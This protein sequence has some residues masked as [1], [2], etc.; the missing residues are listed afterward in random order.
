MKKQD[1][2]ILDIIKKSFNFN[3][4]SYNFEYN[5]IKLAKYIKKVSHIILQIYKKNQN[6]ILIGTNEF[7]SDLLPYYSDKIY[8]GYIDKR[9]IGG[10]ITNW[11]VIKYTIQFYREQLKKIY[12]NKY[13]NINDKEFLKLFRFIDSLKYLQGFPSIIIFLN[14]DKERSAL[15]ECSK[16]K[17]ILTIGFTSIKNNNKINRNLS[18]KIPIKL[19]SYISNVLIL[20]Y[21]S[22]KIK[23]LKN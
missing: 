7:C 9:W 15:I 5:F 21:I 13:I 17:C 12:T 14:T 6:I 11:H 16:K 8:A 19:N 1:L 3:N 22:K 23:N 4:S 10:L 20:D 18:Y 2:I